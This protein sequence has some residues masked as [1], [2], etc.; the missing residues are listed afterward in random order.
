MVANFDMAS[1][2]RHFLAVIQDSQN[3]AGAVPGKVPA[4]IWLCPPQNSENPWLCPARKIKNLP[5]TDFIE[6]TEI[7]GPG[8]INFFL[9][10]NAYQ[11]I[12][13]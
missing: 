1:S 9:S 12:V 7:A 5:K 11:S 4:S 8:F 2:Y 13:L 3:A 6:H 10:K